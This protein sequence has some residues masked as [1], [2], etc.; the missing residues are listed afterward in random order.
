[1]ERM[2]NQMVEVLYS[3]QV[4]GGAHADQSKEEAVLYYCRD[5]EFYVG[6]AINGGPS[7][8][9]ERISEGEL[10]RRLEGHLNSISEEEA[11]QDMKMF[12]ETPSAQVG[13]EVSSG[14][15][16]GLL[17]LLDVCHAWEHIAGQEN[18]IV[19]G[20]RSM[21]C[22]LPAHL[23]KDIQELKLFTIIE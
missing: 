11:E 14:E 15:A 9:D 2:I 12:E 16:Y 18:D 5:G 13:I 3:G 8:M 23:Q 1:M 17:R 21:Y 7:T 20:I 4:I 19:R 6:N 10:R 22:Q